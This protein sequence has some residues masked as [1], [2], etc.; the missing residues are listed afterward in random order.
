MILSF[1]NKSSKWL[2]QTDNKNQTEKKNKNKK[3]KTKP[4]HDFKHVKLLLLMVSLD[5]HLSFPLLLTAFQ[6]WEPQELTPG[7]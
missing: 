2:G 5:Q 4:Q 6:L 1:I 7:K 3:T